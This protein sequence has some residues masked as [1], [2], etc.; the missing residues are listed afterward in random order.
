[1]RKVAPDYHVQIEKHC[2]SVPYSYLGRSVRGLIRSSTVE[3]YDGENR[4]ASHVRRRSGGQYTTDPL[5]MPDHHRKIQPQEGIKAH[6]RDAMVFSD[7]H[8]IH[9]PRISAS[10]GE[11]QK[12]CNAR[13]VAISQRARKRLH[14]RYRAL[15]K[16]KPPKVAVVALARE[17]VGFLW[18]AMQFPVQTA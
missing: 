7:R 9:Y 6:F 4:I 8:Y 12:Q 5:H 3:I 15:A 2:Y 16:R 10:L 1:M 14:Q 11:R 13:T 17:L 18:E